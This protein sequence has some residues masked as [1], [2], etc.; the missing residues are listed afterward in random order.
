MEKSSRLASYS[1]FVAFMTWVLIAAGGLVTSHQAGLS[2]PDWPLSYGKFFPH[3]AGL[4]VWEHSHRVIA[5]FVA[6]FSLVLTVWMTFREKRMKLLG[7]MWLGFGL[8]LLQALLGGLT[9]LLN[10]PHAV[11]M[12]HAVIGQTFFAILTAIAFY[13]SSY[14]IGIQNFAGTGEAK[15]AKFAFSGILL[16]WIQLVIGATVR[17]T[18]H[19][20]V[21]H[22]VFALL[23]AGHL[24]ALV[25]KVLRNTNSNPL[26]IG[27]SV[28]LAGVL[29]FQIFFG[30]GALVLKMMYPPE[31]KPSDMKVAFTV[32]H[33]STGALLL[34]AAVLLWLFLKHPQASSDS[35][36]IS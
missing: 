2:V 24:L 1:I 3:M 8:V 21:E 27:M 11:S 34:C 16:I 19:A 9:V 25:F 14:G 31:V 35:S 22:V 5:G 28:R 7:L 6:I 10:L 13:R 4:M 20:T 23:V 32:L 12:S 26:Q 36:K 18:H 15:L 33:Q 17:H 29:L 30:I